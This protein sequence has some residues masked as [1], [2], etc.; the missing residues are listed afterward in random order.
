MNTHEI[1]KKMNIFYMTSI[2]SL[3]KSD[4]PIINFI[5]GNNPLMTCMSITN[6]N[7]K[8]IPENALTLPLLEILRLSLSTGNTSLRFLYKFTLHPHFQ[9]VISLSSIL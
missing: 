8:S 1:K 9:K 4:Y 5:I 7:L 6:C 3:P 2:F